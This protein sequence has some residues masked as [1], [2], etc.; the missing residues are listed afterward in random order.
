MCINSLLHKTIEHFLNCIFKSNIKY[1][2]THVNNIIIYK[3]QKK[4]KKN[5]YN[6]INK[7]LTNIIICCFQSARG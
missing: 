6:L 4:K 2:H 3:S 5:C 7:N 1:T